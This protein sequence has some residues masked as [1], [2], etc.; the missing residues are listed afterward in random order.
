MTWKSYAAVSG[1]TVLAGWFASTPPANAPSAGAPALAQALSRRGAPAPDIEREATRLQGR[2]RREVAYAQ[3]ERN[4]FRFGATRPTVSAEVDE[5]EVAMPGGT[6]TPAPPPP[7][8]SLSGI[9]EDQIE[10]RVERTAIVSAPAGVL[11]LHEG[12]DV[13][14]QYRVTRI[15]SEA[16]VLVKLVDGT[17]LRLNFTP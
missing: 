11:F 4:P 10:Q 3:P 8:L 6:S 2:V 14:G 1:A 9:A 17:L 12:D 13:L 16:V 7:L 15:E 5:P